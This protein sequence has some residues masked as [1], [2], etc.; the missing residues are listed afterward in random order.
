MRSLK[1]FVVLLL[2]L[3]FGGCGDQPP[4]PCLVDDARVPTEIYVK[5]VDDNGLWGQDVTFGSRRCGIGPKFFSIVPEPPP[6]EGEKYVFE[7]SQN[8]VYS[9]VGTFVSV[10]IV[11]FSNQLLPKTTYTI[12]V[13]DT[14]NTFMHSFTT[15]TP[16]GHLEKLMKDQELSWG[17]EVQCW[18]IEWFW[19]DK[20]DNY[21]VLL[22]QTSENTGTFDIYHDGR[23]VTTMTVDARWMEGNK[24]GNRLIS[25]DGKLQCR[26]RWGVVVL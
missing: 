25:Q 14:K 15:P 16:Y 23:H 11:K 12:S 8:E 13:T 21:L 9:G 22:P 24:G 7:A 3:G 5:E 4:N 18:G 10:L 20:F 19:G 6:Q 1:L 17:T 26:S 2:A